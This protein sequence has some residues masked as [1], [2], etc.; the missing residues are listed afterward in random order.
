MH[1]PLCFCYQEGEH[2]TLPPD[3][4]AAPR[5]PSLFAVVDDL[6]KVHPA[7]EAFTEVSSPAAAEVFLFPWA[8]GQYIDAGRREDIWNVIASLPYFKG[9]ENRHILWDDGDFT[10]AP[11]FPVSLF[12]ISV[13]GAIAHSCVSVPYTLP[14]HILTTQPSFDWGHIA[15]DTS[16]VGNVTNALRKAA[17]ASI[18]RQAPELRLM[19]DFDNAFTTRDGYFFNT[20][21]RADKGEMNR[22]QTLYKES[23]EKSLTVLCPPGVGPYSIRMYETMYM[24]RIPVLFEDESVYPLAMHINYSAFCVRIAKG[25]V[26]AT[27]EI[28]RHWLRDTP[29]DEMHQM[30]ILACRTWN[31]YFAPDKL[32][33]FL[34]EEAKMRFWETELTV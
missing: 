34:L 11:P 8:I 18:K 27:G 16:F 31:R 33:P 20:R 12:K 19:A 15:Y 7:P 13:T 5:A 21:E 6:G 1:K 26:M 9:R 29:L 30:G 14:A 24:G 28:L 22:R 3:F 2:F 23:L 4:N 32:L 17:V 25:D 10:F